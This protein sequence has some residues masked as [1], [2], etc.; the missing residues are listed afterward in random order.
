MNTTSTTALAK[1]VQSLKDRFERLEKDVRG[2]KDLLNV[3]NNWHATIRN[4]VGSDV[5]ICDRS[6]V[7]AGKLLWSDRYNVC[8]EIFTNG[9]MPKERIYTKGGINWIQQA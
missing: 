8:I 5:R 4:W 3:H 7:V 9:N 2:L 6:D 1:K